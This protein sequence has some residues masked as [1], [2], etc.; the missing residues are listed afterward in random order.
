MNRENHNS[1]DLVK[2]IMAIV[3]V[4]IHTR[5]LADFQV[6]I[7]LD[8]YQKFVRLAVP[9]FFVATGYLISLKISFPLKE[10][11]APIIK[12]SLIKFLKLYVIWMLIYTPLSIYHSVE[13]NR[14][15]QEVVLSYIR[16]LFLTGKQYNSSHLWYLLSTIYSLAILHFAARH[17]AKIGH[18]I[19]VGIFFFF[20]SVYS[21]Y[22]VAYEGILPTPFQQIKFIIK[23]AIDSGRMFW[24]MFYIPM[25][26]V[27]AHCSIP[28]KNVGL[29][30]LS[31]II[32]Y[33]ALDGLV[34]SQILLLI[35][36]LL[37]FVFVE[38]IQFSNNKVFLLLRKMSTYIYLIHMY[39]WTFFYTAVY[40][41]VHYGLAAF[42]ATLSVS[43]SLSFAYIKLKERKNL[44]RTK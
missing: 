12:K 7:L 17:K 39:V 14:P 28:K 40:G 29:Y 16:G 24:G 43:C 15:I 31:S 22:I 25:G 1:I 8:F 36:V 13:I 34:L 11:D 9:F 3:V 10:T 27:L 37:F 35:V 42:L 5:P 44:Q 23:N 6:P 33:W 41:D 19:F 2:F 18:V 20:I 38:N 4:A 32:I 26:M 21:D 30:L